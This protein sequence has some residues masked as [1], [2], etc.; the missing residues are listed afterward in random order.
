MEAIWKQDLTNRPECNQK[1]DFSFFHFAC[2]GLRGFPCGQCGEKYS[3][4]SIEKHRLNV[5]VLH[6]LSFLN[7]HLSTPKSN[8]AF[9]NEVSFIL[10]IQLQYY[11][12]KA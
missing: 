10:N 5:A 11:N 7:K 8:K 4:D 6:P 12:Q 1:I 3:R 2:C 9:Q